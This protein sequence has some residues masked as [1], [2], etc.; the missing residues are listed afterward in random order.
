MRK[1]K[2]TKFESRKAEVLVLA[3]YAEQ[4]LATHIS[5]Q[6][7][8]F[9]LSA[10]NNSEPCPAYSCLAF[11]SIRCKDRV[12]DKESYIQMLTDTLILFR[13][14]NPRIWNWASIVAQW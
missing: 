7:S 9:H 10:G 8:F 6:I 12:N 14:F 4:L 2:S 11:M 3:P 13:V 5:S 1:A